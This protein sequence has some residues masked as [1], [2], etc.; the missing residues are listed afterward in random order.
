[1]LYNYNN[2][3]NN[4]VIKEWLKCVSSLHLE[5]NIHW[6]LCFACSRDVE[7]RV[8]NA[9]TSL[10]DHLDSL[11]L[12]FWLAICTYPHHDGRVSFA[13]QQQTCMSCLNLLLLVRVHVQRCHWPLVTLRMGVLVQHHVVCRMVQEIVVLQEHWETRKVCG[14]KWLFVK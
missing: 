5:W 8:R 6:L 10:S 11:A 13:I 7:L 12:S 1:M 14:L 3:N 4:I 2:Y 9:N